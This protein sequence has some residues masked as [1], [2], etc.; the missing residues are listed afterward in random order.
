MAIFLVLL[1]IILLFCNQFSN[2]LSFFTMI[3]KLTLAAGMLL[4]VMQFAACGDHKKQAGNDV[5]DSTQLAAKQG[6]HADSAH[7]HT[8]TAVLKGQHYDI[9]IDRRPDRSLPLVSDDMGRQY[10]DNCVEVIV[11]CEGKL[12]RSKVFTKRAFA[13]FLSDKEKQ[14]TVLLGMAYDAEQSNNS[15]ICLGAQ[16][17]QVG[18]EEGPA[19]TIEIPLDGGAISILRDNNQDTTGNDGL[20]D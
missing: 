8:Y 7:R 2:R 1:L 17:G 16:I 6:P 10:V 19:F 14:G 18:I 20:S 4:F 9:T 11:A 15:H 5:A 12:V 3:K 13:D